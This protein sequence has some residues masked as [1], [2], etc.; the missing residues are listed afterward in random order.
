MKTLKMSPH[1]SLLFYRS[2]SLCVFNPT[3]W[4]APTI[5]TANANSDT[6]VYFGLK[7]SRFV[8]ATFKI[9]PQDFGKRWEN[10]R[11]GNSI[12]SFPP[13]HGASSFSLC[14]LVS[15]K[16]FTLFSYFATRILCMKFNFTACRG[17][18]RSFRIFINLY[19]WECIFFRILWHVRFRKMS[20][21][22]L[23]MLPFYYLL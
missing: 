23:R 18:F 22:L 9:G 19:F 13:E 6:L 8:M 2:L 7:L 20:P 10:S 17:H 15:F 3:A 21:G 14:H 16:Y 12:S 1:K 11:R 4:M 5:Y